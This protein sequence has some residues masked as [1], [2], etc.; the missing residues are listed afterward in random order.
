MLLQACTRAVVDVATSAHRMGL[1][2]TCHCAASAVALCLPIVATSYCCYCTSVG[3]SYQYR[4]FLTDPVSAT[5][6]LIID[7][8]VSALNVSVLSV[9]FVASMLSV[10]TITTEYGR[11]YEW[12]LLH[13]ILHECTVLFIVEMHVLIYAIL[14]F[15]R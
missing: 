11:R 2:M 4:C 6:S 3:V 9:S 13:A 8:I 5:D 15:V 12:Y 14:L 7:T 10:A 1:S